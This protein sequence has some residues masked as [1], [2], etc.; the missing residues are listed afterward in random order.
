MAFVTKKD[1]GVKTVVKGFLTGGTQA[2]IT[3][4]TEYVKTQLQ[5][6]SKTNPE[7]NGI[8]DCAKKTM[9]QHGV[10][11]LYRGAGVRIIGAGFQ[12]MCR[13]GAYTNLT[14][15]FRDPDTGKLS[16]MNNV[17][18]GLGAGICE[19]VCAVT[20]VET[21]KTRVT[22]DQRRG[23]GNYKGSADAIVK[24]MK[25]EGPMGLY[26]GA[27][28]T[29]LKQGTNQAVRMPL[30]VAIF[31]VISMGDES[32]KQNPLLNGAAGFLAGCGSVLLTQP[33]D[34]VK[35]RMQGEAAKELYSGTVDCAM[36]MLNSSLCA[37]GDDQWHQLC[38]L[39]CDQQVAQHGHV[40]AV[41]PCGFC[42]NL[43]DLVGSTS[44]KKG[45]TS[46]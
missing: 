15:I 4:P 17:I 40:R 19:A 3:Y 38:P 7:Y 20:P 8:I 27:F 24:I 33:Q 26:R 35:S 11:G 21:V 2:A 36:K 9:D 25:S 13:W 22:D 30:Q 28:P 10:K 45:G 29:I 34:C 37:G 5:L 18:C 6:Q 14:Q 23:T 44:R 46:Q 42:Q 16:Q 32:K 31:G 39:P 1:S 43:S 41:L 12:Q